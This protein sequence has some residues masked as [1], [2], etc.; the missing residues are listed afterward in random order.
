MDIQNIQAHWPAAEIINPMGRAHVA[1]LCEHAS[2]FIPPGMD[3]LGLTAKDRYSH[4]VWDIGA[5]DTAR[6]LTARFDAPLVACG[7]SRLFYDCNRP[8]EAPDAIPARSEVIDVPGNRDLTDA[9]RALRCQLAHDHFHAAAAFV[10]DSRTEWDAL[11][12]VHSFTPVY[13]GMTREVDIGFLHDANDEL[14]QRALAHAQKNSP[15][16]VALNEPYSATDGVT[17][18]L[19][20]HAEARGLPSLMIE[21]R[22]DLVDALAGA[23]AMADH[24]YSI[25]A[26]ALDEM[27]NTSRGGA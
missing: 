22:N 6:R 15:Y 23:E 1:L 18:S 4:A 2:A 9:D 11:I 12:T 21:V 14:A 26:P 16:K 27:T 17:Y 3:D 5:L 7:L 8:P 24:L 19:R 25:L 10:L 13:K 20:K